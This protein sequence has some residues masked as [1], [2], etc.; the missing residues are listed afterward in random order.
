VGKVVV[1]S[2]SLDASTRV[3]LVRL[4]VN[5]VNRDAQGLAADLL[6]LGFL[7]RDAPAQ[8]VEDALN[9]VMEH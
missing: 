1:S 8:Q 6:S 3:D 7:P 4:L 2:G 5:F 9:K